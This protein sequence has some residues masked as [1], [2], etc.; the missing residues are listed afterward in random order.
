[1]GEGE[2]LRAETE[3][4]EQERGGVV[5]NPLGRSGGAASHSLP[6]RGSGVLD[7][8]GENAP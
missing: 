4:R 7:F 1:L 5:A 6:A 2:L 8:L 3:G